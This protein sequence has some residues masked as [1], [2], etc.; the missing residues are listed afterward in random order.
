MMVLIEN[1]KANEHKIAHAVK[2]N[3]KI[4]QTSHPKKQPNYVQKF[5]STLVE[6]RIKKTY[7]PFGTDPTP[8]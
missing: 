5:I 8:I 1:E 7:R 4:L 3:D 6:G 2:Q